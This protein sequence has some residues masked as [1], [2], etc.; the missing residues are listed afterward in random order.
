M[1]ATITSKGQVTLPKPIRDRLDLKA[2]D[3][4]AFVMEEDGT[5]RVT[6]ITG[7]VMALAGMLPRPATP[8]SQDEMDEVIAGAAVRGDRPR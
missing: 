8:L 2:G 5:L 3:R 7:S 6:P 4:I 1:E